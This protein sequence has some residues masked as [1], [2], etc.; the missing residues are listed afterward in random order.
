VKP[1]GGIFLDK[2]EESNSSV[3]I[4]YTL[5]ADDLALY[6][7]RFGNASKDTNISKVEVDVHRR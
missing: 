2:F 1:Q 5:Q 6:K 7:L 3:D 4:S